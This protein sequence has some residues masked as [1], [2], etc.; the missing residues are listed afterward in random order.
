MA[1][2]DRY[3]NINGYTVLDLIKSNVHTET[4]RV[5]DTDG[6]HYFLK[7]FAIKELPTAM[8]NAK[9]GTVYEI[10]YSKSI[11]HRNIIRAI[12]DGRFDNDRGSYQYYITSYFNGQILADKIATTGKLGEEEALKIFRGLLSGLGH[13]HGL[14]PALCHNDLDISNIIIQENQVE[15][16]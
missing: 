9:T 1:V 6:K 16:L 13:L 12:A 14:S 7:L 10:E 15:N 4:Y 11:N 2:L 8:I 3:D 5:E